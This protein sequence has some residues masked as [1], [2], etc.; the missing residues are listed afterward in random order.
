MKERHLGILLV[1]PAT[2]ILFSVTLFPTIFAYYMSVHRMTLQHF[3]SAPFVGL[4]NYFRVLSLSDFWYSLKFSLLYTVVVTSI[5]ITLGFFLAVY[6]DRP[7]KGRKVLISIIMLPMAIAPALFGILMKL[8]FNDVAG[9]IPYILKNLFKMEVGF[10]SNF[11]SAFLTLAFI[12]IVQWTPF[13]FIILYAAVQALPRAPI[14]AAIVD[15]ASKWQLIRHI[16]IPLLKP[17]ILIVTVF[18]VMDALKTFDTINVI[19]GGGPG[20]L[21]MTLSILVYKLAYTRGD[22][23]LSAAATIIYFLIVIVIANLGLRLLKKGGI[24]A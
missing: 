6:F 18:R 2:V 19:T 17:T 1:L 11:N 22:F 20:N 10:F 24:L 8:M 4:E 14:D 15:G 23:G 9:L 3:W 21:T 16:I 5:E 12:D 7:L 13:V